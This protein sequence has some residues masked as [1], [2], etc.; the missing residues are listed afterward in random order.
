M[1]ARRKGLR[2]AALLAGLLA[3]GP[4]AIGRA[5]DP[6]GDARAHYARGL[7][8]A[9]QNGYE[10]ALREFKAAYAI[11]PQ[12]AVLFNIGQAHIALGHTVEAIEALSR[13]LLDGGDRISPTRRT[14]VQR[15]I[16]GLRSTLPNPEVTSEAEAA[17]A[18]AAA[19]GAA[20]GEAIEAASEGSRA[21]GFTHPGTLTIRCPEP[22]LKLSLDGKRID[23]AASS[24]GVALPAGVHHLVLSA[25]GRRSVEES[26]E[27]QEGGAA[28]VICEMLPAAAAP[29]AIVPLQPIGAPVFTAVTSSAETPT[30]HAKTVA[31]LLGGLG[32][33]FGGT[34]IGVYVWNRGQYK[35]AQREQDYLKTHPTDTDRAIKYNSDV[36]ALNRNSI[37]T[38]GLAA[39]SIG[40]L[41][42]GVYLYLYERRRD[43]EARR[44]SENRTGAVDRLRSWASVTPAGI[45]WNGVW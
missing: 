42:G 32:V 29:P 38:V 30:I 23:L 39:T 18:T 35:E 26:L 33:A 40:L 43:A 16:E 17:R 44:T 6:R 31:Y 21:A 1:V 19:A 3:L 13:Y 2:S 15:Q 11:S 7:E 27:I 9:G 22:G 10:G 20:A 25:A 24:R 36:D 41:A 28:L 45:F 5:D 4:A 34:A 37:V 8:L 14:Q 12:F